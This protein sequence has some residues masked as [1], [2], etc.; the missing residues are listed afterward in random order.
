[1]IAY[2]KGFNIFKYYAKHFALAA[3]LAGVAG[4]TTSELENIGGGDST[5]ILISSEISQNNAQR[6]P[7]TVLRMEIR[8]EPLLLTGRVTPREPLNLPA[9][10]PT[11]CTIP[12]TRQETAGYPLMMSISK[13]TTLL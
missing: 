13:M 1:M 12:T 3:L 4:C 7:R 6:Q 10:V 2:M 9:T 8:L 11:T 5:P